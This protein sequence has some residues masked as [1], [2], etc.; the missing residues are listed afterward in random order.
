MS[1][2]LYAFLFLA[3]S[4]FTFSGYAMGGEWFVQ[5][6]YVRRGTVFPNAVC[7]FKKEKNEITGV[8]RRSPKESGTITPAT[9]E[10]I[11]P[12]TVLHFYYYDLMTAYR[13]SFSFYVTP[14]PA[15]LT[16]DSKDLTSLSTE[17]YGSIP[18]KITNAE[19]M[20]L[21][22][23]HNDEAMG[24]EGYALTMAGALEIILSQ[25]IP[26][27]WEAGRLAHLE[28]VTITDKNE[29][30]A[31][32]LREKASRCISAFRLQNYTPVSSFSSSWTMIF[33]INDQ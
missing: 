30:I 25:Y 26:K 31:T 15:K 3:A 6:E 10:L 33:R 21:S 12:H 7:V 14:N 16:K 27:V 19:N 29:S 1:K 18:V 22:I 2:F 11:S 8:V 4:F 20:D 32:T 17:R 5:E 28:T 24:K 9:A 13:S 23:L